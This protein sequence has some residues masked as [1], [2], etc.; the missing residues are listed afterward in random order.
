MPMVS[1]AAWRQQGL[2]AGGAVARSL[3]A[4]HEPHPQGVRRAAQHQLDSQAL[5]LLSPAALLLICPPDEVGKA[6]RAAV[7]A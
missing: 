7:V 5:Q 4:L 6:Q 3:A 1:M 2:P